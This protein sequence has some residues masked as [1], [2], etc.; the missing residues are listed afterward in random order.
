MHF[1]FID[2]SL[3]HNGH[4]HVSG[5]LQGSENKNK[6]IIITHSLTNSAVNLNKNFIIFNC[7]VI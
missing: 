4:Q 5:H 7:G 3:L 6:S 1:S 2:V